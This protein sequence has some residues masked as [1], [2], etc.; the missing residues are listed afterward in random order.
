MCA[1]LGPDL[2]LVYNDATI[3]VLGN[4][5]PSIGLPARRVFPEIW[6]SLSPVFARVLATGEPVVARDHPFLLHRHRFLE[7]CFFTVSF[8]A[9][10]DDDGVPT[11]VLATGLET[12]R[13]VRMAR[14]LTCLE[15]LVRTSIGCE[16]VGQLAVR[17]LTTM[18]EH[19]P[20]TQYAAFYVREGDSWPMVSSVGLPAD[21][22]VQL[23]LHELAEHGE[24]VL[25]DAERGQL[26]VMPLRTRQTG[27]AVAM[28]VATVNHRRPADES[29]EF[30]KSVGGY[31]SMAIG[32]IQA[33]EA[34][35][36]ARQA[37]EVASRAKDDFLAMLSHELRSPLSAILGWIG[38]LR[39][40]AR[41]PRM[42]VEAAEVIER[43]A[44]AQRHLVDDLLDVTHITTGELRVDLEPLGSLESII[45]SIVASWRPTAEAMGV[46]LT[47]KATGVTGPLRADPYRLEQVAWNL[48]SNAFKFTPAA[49]RVDVRI[50]RAGA[51]VVLTVR[52]T[53]P[54]IDED[55]LPKI[56]DR[57]YQGPE[58]GRRPKGIGLG[59]SIA[60]EIV[61]RHG[62]TIDAVNVELE[63]GAVF[64]VRLPIVNDDLQAPGA[65][66]RA[67]PASAAPSSS[68]RVLLVE[69]DRSA[70]TA[71]RRFLRSAGHRVRLAATVAD[72]RQAIA[73]ARF[74]VV[75]S[76]LALPDGNGLD[77]LRQLRASSPAAH[78]LPG[79]L[80]SGFAMPAD[81]ES[82][83][84]A[85]YS[86]HVAKPFD[87]DDLLETIR[88]VTE[89]AAFRK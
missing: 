33:Q 11:G 19:E 38:W 75:I 41:H 12:T 18:A 44:R 28:L 74:D 81:A 85:G 51:E 53:G 6:D 34:E 22:F 45:D 87:A 25:W 63:P 46:R 54:G 49:G 59:L 3:P 40:G 76:D 47:Y 70:A 89:P 65:D 68:R 61:L 69:D 79:I 20:T 29:L 78:A 48:L 37:A 83:L 58:L 15:H 71:T 67:L 21:E 30:L 8:S 7:Q 43:N 52:D 86:A 10:R 4:K 72:A 9:I 64:T 82:A 39:K 84:A 23:P 27:A 42:V 66:A 56:F 31:L 62:G 50:D 57:F 17:A 32:H 35:Q 2:I 36:R 16:S 1:M 88:R 14:R 26:C 77:L 5:H 13:A 80:L 73:S 55:H 60:R 24:P